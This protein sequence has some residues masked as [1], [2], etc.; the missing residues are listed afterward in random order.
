MVNV[1]S[2]TGLIQPKRRRKPKFTPVN[3]FSQAPA[4]SALDDEEPKAPPTTKSV[5]QPGFEFLFGII[6]T[7]NVGN[8][9]GIENDTVRLFANILLDPI[10]IGA[11]F[12]TGGLTAAGKVASATKALKTTKGVLRS[13]KGVTALE[14]V[15]STK[16]FLRV[17][18]KAEANPE[19]TKAIQAALKAE[20]AMGFTKA[21]RGLAKT[22]VSSGLERLIPSTDELFKLDDLLQAE[23]VFESGAALAKVNKELVPGLVKQVEAGQ[24]SLIQARVPFTN[25]RKTVVEGKPIFSILDN[26]FPASPLLSKTTTA[27]A[28]G[29]GVAATTFREMFRG[30][31]DNRGV[32]MNDITRNSDEVIKG[33]KTKLNT[34]APGSEAE[35]LADLLFFARE[36]RGISKN[37]VEELGLIGEFERLGIKS[38]G[39]KEGFEFFDKLEFDKFIKGKGW[40]KATKELGRDLGNHFEDLRLFMNESGLGLDIPHVENYI[41]RLWDVEVKEAGKLAKDWVRTGVFL[42]KR[43]FNTA[44]QGLSKSFKLKNTNAFDVLKEYQL[45]S[46]RIVQNREIIET[47]KSAKNTIRIDNI[48]IPLLTSER[49]LNRLGIKGDYTKITD[50]NLRRVIGISGIRGAREWMPKSAARDLGVIFGR[51]F[52]GPIA[53][54]ADKFNANAKFLQLASSFFHSVALTESAIATLGPVKGIKTAISLGGGLP[55]PKGIR[56]ALLKSGLGDNVVALSDDAANSAIAAGLDVARAPD[57][58][59]NLVQ[60]GLQTIE[61]TVTRS[62]PGVGKMIG[63]L[64]RKY[65]EMFNEALWDNYHRP[66]K[67][68]GY[69]DRLAHLKKISPNA[70]PSQ[71]AAT[72][73]S[74]INDAFGGQNWERLLVHPKF[75]Q[76]MHWSFLAPDWTISNLRIAGIGSTGIKG[77][78]RGVLGQGRNGKEELVGAYWRTALPVMY[79]MSNILNRASSGHWLWENAPGHKLDIEL[80]ERDEKGKLSYVKLG[81]QFR[82]PFRW[83]TEPDKIF[84]AKLAP[85]VQVAVEQLTAHST[86]GFPTELAELNIKKV[87]MTFMEKVPTRAK[88]FVEKFVPFSFRGNNFMMALPKSTFSERDAILGVADAIKGTK[89]TGSDSLAVREILKLAAANGLNVNRIKGAVKREVGDPRGLLNQDLE[90]GGLR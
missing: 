48:E 80:A 57:F 7:V 77:A 74:F 2:G 84:G 22:K 82:E 19:A 68:I 81:K 47:I 39:A 49:K 18:A 60:K 51:P 9:L 4:I 12:F 54:F 73:A 25:I 89:F 63:S 75:K 31:L 21:V 41:T 85:G 55:L 5:E 23:K 28:R 1:F 6:P 45:L 88:I 58:Q 15:N 70:D 90:I 14:R 67:L 42:N 20:D 53:K 86:T 33:L 38:R 46:G 8:I 87:P 34:L 72:A 66:L 44:I 30:M 43:K 26:L 52:D 29:S 32:F 64:P 3:V 11:A 13:M 83:L 62:I 56:T 37:V 27:V 61:S 36:G 76:A 79:A 69:Q 24:R 50:E 10:S 17:L 40:E 59:M 16:S 65:T 78:V 71:L 35:G